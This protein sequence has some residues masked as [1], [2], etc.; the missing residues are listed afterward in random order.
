MPPSPID[1]WTT[2]AGDPD[3][4]GWLTVVLYVVA[5]VLTCRLVGH[6]P[7]WQPN[8]DT[9]RERLFWKLLL[10]GLFGLGLNKQLDLQTLMI[11]SARALALEQ[12][13]YAQRHTLQVGAVLAGGATGLALL[14]LTGALI[15]RAPAITSGA[16]LGT[17]GLG[18]YALLR[19]SRF[20]HIDLLPGR[21]PLA[22]TLS[23]WLEIGGLLLISVSAWRRRGTP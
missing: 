6:Q 15:R 3:F 14:V 20:Q 7:T 8:P 23:H 17:A 2:S 1:V 19:L 18:A 16:M 13:W 9:G 4:R 12:G 11:Q 21:M 22:T 10:L 5:T